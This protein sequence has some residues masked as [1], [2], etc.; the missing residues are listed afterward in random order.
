M[1]Q[2]NRLKEKYRTSLGEKIKEYQLSYLE[3][4][5]RMPTYQILQKL[6][7]CHLEGR[8]DRSTTEDWKDKFVGTG[9]KA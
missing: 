4:I 2:K 9:L 1:L 6:Y 7:G 3:Q 5:I 8:R